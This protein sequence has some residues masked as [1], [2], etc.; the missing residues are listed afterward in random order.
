MN[1]LHMHINVFIWTYFRDMA[2]IVDRQGTMVEEIV[3]S[4]EK[5]HDRAQAGLDQ[6][7][8]AAANQK[9]CIVS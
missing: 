5:S 4:T 9:S 2:E 7:Q 8:K 1:I 6:V 3:V